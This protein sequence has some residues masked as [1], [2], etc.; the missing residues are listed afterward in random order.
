MFLFL[1]LGEKTLMIYLIKSASWNSKENKFEFILKIGYTGDESAKN[2]FS[3]YNNHNPTIEILFKIPEA[4]E[5]QEMALHEYFKK[6]RV[7]NREWY[8][9]NEEIIEFFKTHTTTESL[10]SEQ[11]LLMCIKTKD[12]QPTKADFINGLEESDLKIRLQNY[13]AEKTVFCRLKFLCKSENSFLLTEPILE[14]LP[15]NNF[16]KYFEVLGVDRIR[17]LGCNLGRVN[18]ELGI[19][20]FSL[21][22]LDFDIYQEFSEGDMVS[23]SEIKEKLAIIYKE[24]GFEKKPKTTDLQYWFDIEPTQYRVGAKRYRGLKL[25]ERLR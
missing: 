24:Y 23:S 18:K 2:R 5:Q 13:V 25:N 16:K 22:D 20:T 12:Q 11:D 10:N 1:K 14:M 21:D 7:Y 15:E 3:S 17:A 9:Y 19:K 4:T 8:E 6:F